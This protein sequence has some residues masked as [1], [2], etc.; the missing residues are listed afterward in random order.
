MTVGGDIVELAYR[1]AQASGSNLSRSQVDLCVT[2]LEMG[3][4][5]EALG[6]IISELP[7]ALERRRTFNK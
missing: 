3:V 2:L 6:H 1:I 5:P 7:A 4:T